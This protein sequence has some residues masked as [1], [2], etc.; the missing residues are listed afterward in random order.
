[1]P[2]RYLCTHKK[3]L[4]NNNLLHKFL[5]TSK[6]SQNPINFIKL[7]TLSLFSRRG[8]ILLKIQRLQEY[9][10][11]HCGPFDRLKRLLLSLGG[12]F[13]ALRARVG[14]RPQALKHVFFQKLNDYKNNIK[15]IFSLSPKMLV[16][17]GVFILP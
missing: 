1:M 9:I 6:Q 3:N 14:T 11:C 2:V 17:V 7:R 12:F 5:K 15:F 4:P 10:L 16:I 8:N 13:T